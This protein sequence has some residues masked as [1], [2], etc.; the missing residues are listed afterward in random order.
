MALSAKH[1][2]ELKAAALAAGVDWNNLIELFKKVGPLAF[3]LIQ[4]I[5]A[6]LQPA[7]QP[8]QSGAGHTCGPDGC[9]CCCACAE[10]IKLLA[11]HICSCCGG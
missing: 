6:N 11:D 2:S 5:L 4:L 3:Q 10:T 9:A 7:P 1:E 8:M